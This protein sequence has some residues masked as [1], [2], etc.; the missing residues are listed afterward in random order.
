MNTRPRYEAL[1]S[2]CRPHVR[3]AR[4]VGELPH[5]EDRL[6]ALREAGPSVATAVGQPLIRPLAFGLPISEAFAMTRTEIREHPLQKLLQT[7]G[8]DLPLSYVPMYAPNGAL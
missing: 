4:R 2:E 7:R 5:S 3:E 8:E 1:D 6:S